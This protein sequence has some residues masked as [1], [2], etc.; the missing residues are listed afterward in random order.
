MATRT[1]EE[2]REELGAG[3][4][5]IAQMAPELRALFPDLPPAPA[6]EPEQARFRFFESCSALL[7]RA[8]AARTLVLII[9]DLHWADRSSLLL[10]EFLARDVR[11]MRVLILCAYREIDP[12][13]AHPLTATLAAL[14]R[15]PAHERLTLGGLSEAAITA[16][17][18]DL[19]PFA[20]D[21]A[22]RARAVHERTE[23][24]P[25]FIQET[26]RH[27]VEFGA[28][29]GDRLPAGVPAG[30][31][32]VIG[33]RIARLSQ[34]AR[35]FLDRAAVLGREFSVDLVARMVS[36]MEQEASPAVA[37]LDALMEV[38]GARLVERIA[39]RPDRYRFVHALVRET[40]Y[41]ALG[42]ARRSRLHLRAG[43][44]LER[45]YADDPAPHLTAIAHHLFEGLPGGD[46]VRA[47][48]YAERAGE[49]ALTML[50]FDEAA[51]HFERAVRLTE[52]PGSGG[53]RG[54]LLLRLGEARFLAGAEHHVVRD[55]ALEA[56]ALAR[57]HDDAELL[58]RAVLLYARTRIR[59]FVQD[60]DL[61][62]LLHEALAAIGPAD[63]P[64]RVRL[65]SRLVVA[66]ATLPDA[67]AEAAEAGR[68]ALAAARRLGDPVSLVHALMS[69]H[70]AIWTPENAARRL[71][72]A[73]EASDIAVAA[74]ITELDL[75]DCHGWRYVALL[76]LGEVVA[77][78]DVLRGRM[79]RDEAL[80]SPPA[81]GSL[82][83]TRASRALLAG[84]FEA[85]LRFA[86]QAQRIAERMGL[87][88]LAG[89]PLV[90][91][92]FLHREQG[93]L[94]E[95][96]AIVN[97]L[98]RALPMWTIVRC[99][100]AV[101]HLDLGR[102]AEAREAYTRL[103]AGDMAGLSRGF[104]QG[105]QLAAPLLAELSIA[106]ADRPRAETLYA[107][108]LPLSGHIAV[109]SEIACIGAADRHLGLLATLLE[110]W[111]EAE[112]HFERAVALN[113][114][115]GA[116][117]WLAH[118]RH[119]YAATLLSRDAPGDRDR[120]RPLLDQADAAARSLGM[121]PLLARIE[122]TRRGLDEVAPARP[123]PS[124]PDGLTPREVAVLR[125]VAAGLTNRQIAD[126]L[127]LS[128]RTVE[129]HIAHIYEKCNLAGRAEATL[130]A[131][132]HGLIDTAASSR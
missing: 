25:F 70:L 116:A 12:A 113:H 16:M 108:L 8:A 64:W 1:P 9:D 13:A 120:V 131:V 5:D 115:T 33:L 77:A 82:L 74:G 100:A 36:E 4:A 6:L 84:E 121:P 42:P 52:H 35:E 119:D 50:A 110:R 32:E 130:Y 132:R 117:P 101:L 91:R 38:E 21:A 73:S 123:V 40:V 65:L 128:A 20:T 78:D 111:L 56:V 27:L 112:R 67:A 47:L 51:G 81:R 98:E 129:R 71:E 62:R 72:L 127:V 105:F 80:R 122:A 14:R 19:P 83:M 97:G 28:E 11:G 55:H 90:T 39:G 107:L 85:G 54:A 102:M 109:Y 118:T 17:L 125:F 24:N 29:G 59:Y 61:V 18:L 2:L 58:T 92:F 126:E 104:G 26:L 34:P 89:Q 23:G 49:R 114:R 7:G 124:H 103:V 43:E 53:R 31:R 48:D 15:D 76:E 79:R 37:W 63:S 96:E 3:A 57:R 95:D 60:H 46:V 66:L 93:R 22:R 106:F 30:V 10:L 68:Q 41:E 99:M 75:L 88:G 94:A 45:L 44:M 87:R 86:M 69:V